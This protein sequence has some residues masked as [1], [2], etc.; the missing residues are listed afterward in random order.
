M[1][2]NGKMKKINKHIL[3]TFFTSKAR[4]ISILL[5]IFLASF[6]YVGLKATAFNM[7]NTIQHHFKETN[8]ADIFIMSNYGFDNEDL[9]LIKKYNI[10]ANYFYDL[11]VKDNNLIRVFN[12]PQKISLNKIVK[13]R[14]I[15]G[16]NEILISENLESKYKLNDVVEFKD[17]DDFNL[18][19]N[20]Y[21]I[22]GFVQNPEFLSKINFSTSNKGSGE[23]N[24]FA[25]IDKNNFDS[26]YHHLVKI[27]SEN[28][29][30][31][32]YQNNIINLKTEL[33][34]IFKNQAV[35]RLSKI[36]KDI[37]TKI[38]D[39]E[40]ELEKQKQ[41]LIDAENKFNQGFNS[42]NENKKELNEKYEL[43]N[44]KEKELNEAHSS[45]EI[46]KANF[47]IAETKLKDSKIQ[48]ESLD[49]QIKE[50]E[51]KLLNFQ[52]NNSSIEKIELENTLSILKNT[53]INGWNEYQN[54]LSQFNQNK[55]YFNNKYNEYING[56]YLV[57]KNKTEIKDGLSKIEKEELDLTQKYQDFL[58]TK[59]E[60]LEKI[61]DA[62]LEIEDQKETIKNL[63]NV[64]YKIYDREDFITSNGFLLYKNN[65]KIINSIAIVFS[66]ILYIIV[67]IL[68]LTTMERFINEEYKNIGIL[69]AIGYNN[70]D[71]IK[72]FL[73]YGISSTFIGTTLGILCGF[74]LMPLIVYN[75][76]KVSFSIIPIKLNVYYMEIIVVYLLAFFS[77]ILPVITVAFKLKSS[78]VVDLITP[79]FF[80]NSHKI[81]LENLTFLW[82][83]LS[84]K[85]KVNLRNIFRYKKRMFMTLFGISG[86]LIL[87]IVGLG[88][89]DSIEAIE[90]KQYQEI[91]K[92]DIL[93]IYQDNIN[94][95]EIAEIKS[96]LDKSIHINFKTFKNELDENVNV[97]SGSNIN[98]YIKFINL[99]DQEIQGDVL[100]T[101]KLAKNLN[102]KVND[103][104]TLKDDNTN[105][106]LKVN[107]II[108]MYSGHYVFLSENAYSKIFNQKFKIN[109]ALIKTDNAIN[110]S[111][112]LL[113]H[114]QVKAIN[115]NL[116]QIKQIKTMV[117]SLKGVI[118]L[119][120]TAS[121][122]LSYVVLFN[123]NNI[124]IEERNR[125]LST[126]KV[127]GFYD[128]EVLKYIYDE[129]IY[130]TLV[131]L[132]IGQIV[133]FKIY[134]LVMDYISLDIFIFKAILS[135]NTV[136]IPSFLVTLILI[137]L[138]ILMNNKI[139]KINMLESLK[140][141]D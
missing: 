80:S 135:L 87:L 113:K 31:N 51:N 14:D 32:S 78:K 11:E 26:K 35:T 124:N 60:A 91:F 141:V 118:V 96:K 49:F 12:N 46:A 39:A 63:E 20:S 74:I 5:L 48:L 99:K 117:N 81:L 97:I 47:I 70:F 33:E 58:K 68:I 106:D 36:Q 27:K 89:K 123:L 62:K 86:S 105:Y 111:T 71:I 76:Y 109:A 131:A 61:N 121:A 8:F 69:K 126:I 59:K 1:I 100:I 50:L 139:K 18:K 133:G 64:Q 101:E 94:E 112:E 82:T 104:L 23:I 77:S 93:T 4:F 119:L 85:Q 29:F 17:N 129:T 16:L 120:L 24:G 66:S 52:E 114:K 79:Q 10:E 137:I 7:E 73:Y 43:L 2:W 28:S 84:F 90:T 54:S 9:D 42:I 128:K 138:K 116:T 19:N 110:L 37:D 130:L 132:I 108:Q 136:I 56:S 88:I 15:N 53:S 75:T 55:E 98:D 83:K 21:K 103:Y 127:L 22:V 140:S 40:N 6:A 115:T 45:L 13:G 65:I 30:S 67:S 95:K 3:N 34:N 122:M 25:Y 125:E 57:S 38:K 102:I 72:K 44:D 107:G 92:Y 41:E 134:K